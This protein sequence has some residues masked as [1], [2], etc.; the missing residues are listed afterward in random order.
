MDIKMTIRV[1]I[2]LEFQDESTHKRRNASGMELESG[3]TYPPGT[4]EKTET[5]KRQNTARP[6]SLPTIRISIREESSQPSR[7]GRKDACIS[8]TCS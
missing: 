5:D 1:D 7:S 4:D 8:V 6:L 3:R 2:L